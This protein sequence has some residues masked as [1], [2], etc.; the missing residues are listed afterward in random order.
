MADGV[1][2]HR[3]VVAGPQLAAVAAR[4]HDAADFLDALGLDEV[5]GALDDVFG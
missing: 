4:L 5:E 1:D 2:A 3:E